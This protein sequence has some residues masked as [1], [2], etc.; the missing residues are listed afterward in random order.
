V[1]A[2]APFTQM[3]GLLTNNGKVSKVLLNAID[4]ALERQVS[5]IDNFMQQGKLDD[6]VPGEFGIVI[7]DKAAA[8]LG[9]A[10]GDKLTFRRAGSH[11]DPGR[12]VPAH[13]ALHRGRHLPCRRR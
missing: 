2:V 10:I 9:A 4:P 11:R 8:K 7:G 1:T 12:D 13:E 3:Q 5:I 6:L